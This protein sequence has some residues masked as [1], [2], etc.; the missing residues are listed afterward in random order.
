MM[1]KLIAALVGL[2]VLT[3]PLPSAA[4]PERVR[5]T[6]YEKVDEVVAAGEFAKVYDPSVGEAEPWYYND[7]TLVQDRAT[8]TWHV[9]AITHAEPANP[10]DEKSFGHATAPTPNGPWTKQPPALIADPAA[11]ESHI[12]AP[13]VM[14]HEGT[15]YMFYAAG[16]PDHTAYRMHLA[17]S[18]DL[19][20]WTRDAANPLFTDGFDGRDPMVRKVGDQWVMYYTANSTPAGGNHIVA[21]R[22][23]TDLKHWSDRQTAFQH[24]ST[25][26]FG[27]PTESPF[28][29]QRGTDWYL[30]VCCDGGYESTKVYKSEDP[31]HF[32]V[33]QLAGTIPAHA[34]EVVQDG[35]DWYVTGAGWGKGGLFIAP[36]DFAELQVTKGRVVTTN[37]YRATIE[38]SPRAALTG[39]DVDPTGRRNYRPALDSTGRSTAPYLAVGNFGATDLSGPAAHVDARRTSLTL[40]GIP[41][42]DEPVAADW[43]FDFGPTTFDT[44]LAWT[45]KAP[46]NAPVWEVALNVDSALPDQGDPG[47][48]GRDGDVAGLPRWSMA[49]GPGLS[50]VTAYRPGS[51][52]S[53]DNHWYDPSNGAVAWQPLW[54]PGGRALPPG[55]YDGGCWRL[56]FSGTERDVAFADSLAASVGT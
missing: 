9:Y 8:G 22:T 29:V 55:K 18:T 10:L 13:Y 25:G 15:Y 24:P 52:W 39:L 2:S 48:F 31:L 49:T 26:T 30:F 14:Y 36:L 16:T 38:T 5:I 1:R 17:T 33:D 21:Y 27:G 41:F 56:G 43:T 54:Q 20:H 32:T 45:V 44:R 19:V 28:V 42:G 46:T 47:G 7:H 23:S 40:R 3:V 4:S 12:W 11:G 35:Q 34:A 6:P 37:H 50:V 51:A 53:E